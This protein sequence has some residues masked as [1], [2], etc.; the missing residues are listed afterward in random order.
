MCYTITLHAKGGCGHRLPA[1]VPCNNRMEYDP[2]C[3]RQTSHHMWQEE[4]YCL[5]CFPTELGLR[6]LP[7]KYQQDIR[8]ARRKA[9]EAAQMALAELEENAAAAA[10]TVA[11]MGS[12][13]RKA[14]SSTAK[15][16]AHARV[17][18]TD[19]AGKTRNGE[20][21]EKQRER[22]SSLEQLLAYEAVRVAA[23]THGNGRGNVPQ[24][25][26]KQDKTPAVDVPPAGSFQLAAWLP[27]WGW[28]IWPTRWRG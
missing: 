11:S 27:F 23:D 7:L 15:Q 5:K 28:S 22:S 9:R 17:P 13:K 4:H 1:G 2:H 19:L 20:Y 24:Q 26:E 8:E 18:V 10:A 12:N 25:T 14:G 16:P 6:L 21:M 3:P